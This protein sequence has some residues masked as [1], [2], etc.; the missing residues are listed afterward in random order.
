MGRVPWI[1]QVGLISSHKPLKAIHFLQLETKE[2]DQRRQRD[3]KQEKHV[4]VVGFKDEKN[5][6]KGSRN[7]EPMSGW[8][9]PI[10]QGPQSYNQT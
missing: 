1:I 9:P 6:N 10:I 8:Q 2:W 3:L 5:H 7:L 4:T